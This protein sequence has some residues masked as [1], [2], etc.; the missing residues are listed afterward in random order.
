MPISFQCPECARPFSVDNKLAGKK[1]RCCCGLLVRVPKRS[2]QAQQPSTRNNGATMN[3]AFRFAPELFEFRN[4]VIEE[5]TD[6]GLYWLS[7]YSTVD[8]LHDV[9]GIEVCG[10]HNR[11]DAVQILKLLKQMF[12]R[13]TP[14]RIWY[15]DY[16]IGLGWIATVQRDPDP[17]DEKWES[18]E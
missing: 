11:E 7:H 10:I 8:P 12:P 13:W 6:A 2:A 9:Y 3:D 14:E 15:K 18:A 17:P 4:N 1:A 5:L 16:G